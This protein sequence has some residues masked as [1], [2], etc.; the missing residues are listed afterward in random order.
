MLAKYY[1]YRNLNR[2]GFSVKHKGLVIDR[3][4]EFAADNVEFRVSEASR[5]RAKR[6]GRRNV[7]A[8]LVC[9]EYQP[10][11]WKLNTF[12]KHISENEMV[13]VYYHPLQTNSFVIAGTNTPVTE[14]EHVVAFNGKAFAIPKYGD[15]ITQRP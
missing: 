10:L 13:Q 4:D 11:K 15:E 14:S 8:Y 1:I 5:R 6:E 9:D 3:I 2:G 12:S 7:H